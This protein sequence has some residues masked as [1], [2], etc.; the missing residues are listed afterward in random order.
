MRPRQRRYIADPHLGHATL[1][2]LRGYPT[3]AAHDAAFLAAWYRSVPD[4]ATEVFVLGDLSGGSAAGE[5]HAL[6]RLGALPGVKHLILGNH[7]RAHPLHKNGRKHLLGY[8]E[9]F[10]SVLIADMVSLGGHDVMLSH[11]PHTGDHDGTPDRHAGW[12]L[13][14]TGR[15]L[16][17]G[18]VHDAWDVRGRQI[19]VSWERWPTRFPTDTDITALITA[20]QAREERTRQ[21]IM[22][23]GGGS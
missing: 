5:A 9:V 6:A 15:W 12:R 23:G 11:F 14:D 8:Y 17:H 2:T 10:A 20:G 7:D 13:P 22:D 19:N 21:M 1:A 3:V 4:D 16:L 18:H